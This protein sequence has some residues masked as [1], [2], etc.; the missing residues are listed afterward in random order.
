MTQEFVRRPG[1]GGKKSRSRASPTPS[2][3]KNKTCNGV[4]EFSPQKENWS[5]GYK[6]SKPILMECIHC[7]RT[8][9]MYYSFIGEQFHHQ[10]EC[11][12]CG[13]PNGPLEAT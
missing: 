10:L 11:G 5:G 7:K 6:P 9:Y 4:G 8:T 12:I 2:R 1:H 13:K 3:E